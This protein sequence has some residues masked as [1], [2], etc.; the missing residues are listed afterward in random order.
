M[1]SEAVLMLW[2]TDESL[3]A[4][5]DNSPDATQTRLSRLAGFVQFLAF[6][7]AACAW[8]RR[9]FREIFKA[10]QFSGQVAN[11]ER[12]CVSLFEVHVKCVLPYTHRKESWSVL[13]TF[14]LN[15]L[16]E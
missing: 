9:S 10:R 5:E 3:A 4:S 15:L 11:F 13:A 16:P 7:L 8:C 12:V 1:V 14:T 2:I 6:C